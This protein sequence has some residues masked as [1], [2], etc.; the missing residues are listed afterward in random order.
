MTDE[1]RTEGKIEEDYPEDEEAFERTGLSGIVK[2]RAYRQEDKKQLIELYAGD[3][4]LRRE[5]SI[6]EIIGEA[7]NL[8]NPLLR[9]VEV[10]SGGEPPKIE[11]FVAGYG[12]MKEAYHFI[13]PFLEGK[14]GFPSMY[15]KE[16]GVSGRYARTSIGW[17]LLEE[18][19]ALSKAARARSIVLPI[20]K[21]SIISPMGDELFSRCGYRQLDLP[22]KEGE[23]TD[24]YGLH[25]MTMTKVAPYNLSD[26]KGYLIKWL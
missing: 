20:R 2:T 5:K 10:A 13:E 17:Y 18:F 11:G 26:I 22:V 21:K 23:D 7:L 9:V 12:L 24:V 16:L 3:S 6:E 4:N 14:M 15:L 19:E 8:P 1:N 25:L